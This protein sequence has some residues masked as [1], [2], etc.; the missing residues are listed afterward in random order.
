[1]RTTRAMKTQMTTTTRRVTRPRQQRA[2]DLT[3]TFGRAQEKLSLPQ[4]YERFMESL[5]PGMKMI[6]TCAPAGCALLCRCMR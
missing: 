6:Y 1:M 2:A 4:K 3:L 5:S